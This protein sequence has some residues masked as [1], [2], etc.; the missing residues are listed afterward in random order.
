M[1]KDLKAHLEDCEY[2][3]ISCPRGQEKC[4]PKF[5]RDSEKAHDAVCDKWHCQITSLCTTVGTLAT[6]EIHRP[7][8][9]SMSP[10]KAPRSYGITARSHF[11]HSSTPLSLPVLT[12][13]PAR[14]KT[15]TN[16]N[17]P[18]GQQS[19]HQLLVDGST[20]LDFS[21]SVV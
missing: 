17:H 20:T 12:L 4:G 8:C 3:W 11:S 15:E 16:A 6:L 19:L 18:L 1:F 10:R 21:G 14:P 13:V 5:R 9:I 7:G 2:D